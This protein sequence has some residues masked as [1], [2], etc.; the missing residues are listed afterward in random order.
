MNG[1]GAKKTLEEDRSV[2]PFLFAFLLYPFLSCGATLGTLT[3][4][5]D[6]HSHAQ[7]RF[8]LEEM[9]VCRS[10]FAVRFVCFLLLSANISGEGAKGGFL[11]RCIQT[12]M[13]HAETHGETPR[14]LSLACGL[15]ERRV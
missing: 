5:A 3:F 1:K 13:T 9:V 8:V 12:K 6:V 15:T 4:V 14:F 10:P 7:D 11:L 2:T